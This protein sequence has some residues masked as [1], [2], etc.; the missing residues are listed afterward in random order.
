MESVTWEYIAT[1]GGEET[2]LFLHGMTGANDIWWQQIEALKEHRRVISVTYPPVRSLEKLAK[3]VLSILENEKV[4]NANIV[5]T[6][7][8]GYFTQHLITRYPE[9]V[10]RAVLSNTFPPN[11]LIAEKK[12]TIGKILPYLPEWLLLSV[13]RSNF[14][15]TIYPTSGGEELTIAFLNELS[16][17]RMS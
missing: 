8:G 6:S 7:L 12:C 9:R 17:G 4:E 14:L 16:N 10:R 13:F 2:V 3:G 5:G 15:R 11:N 1:G